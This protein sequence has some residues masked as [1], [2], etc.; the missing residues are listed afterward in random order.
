MRTIKISLNLGCV[1]VGNSL[2]R[3]ASRCWREASDK[4][5]HKL[6]T[7][8]RNNSLDSDFKSSI[9]GEIRGPDPPIKAQN[10]A[11]LHQN[12]TAALMILRFLSLSPCCTGTP[13]LRH[14]CYVG[15]P[16]VL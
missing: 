4:Q 14:W 8:G 2:F 5:G 13:L 6:H 11:P 10:S 9:S 7:G 1:L 12:A 15:S 16:R 3:G